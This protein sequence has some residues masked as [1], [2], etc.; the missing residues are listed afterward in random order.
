M[1]EVRYERILQE[2]SSAFFIQVRKDKRVWLPKK[3]VE[4]DKGFKTVKVP[5]KIAMDRGIEYDT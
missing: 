1:L 3:F 4:V 2:T 5:T